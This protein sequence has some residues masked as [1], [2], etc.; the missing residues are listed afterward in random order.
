LGATEIVERIRGEFREMPGLT[1]TTEQAQ[2]LWNLDSPTCGEV[3]AS[4]VSEG[5]L[6]VKP[7]GAYARATDLTAHPRRMA[8]ATLGAF[9]LE[10]IRPAAAKR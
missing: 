9:E 1:L 4:L 7:N 5:F 6:R 8:R 10:R 3:L 2:R